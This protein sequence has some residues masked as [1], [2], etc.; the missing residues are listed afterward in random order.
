MTEIFIYIGI[1]IWGF[2]M[3]YVC[4]LGKKVSDNKWKDLL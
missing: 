2:A 4:K 1:I 3:I